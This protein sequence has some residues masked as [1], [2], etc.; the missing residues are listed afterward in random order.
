[1]NPDGRIEWLDT[2]ARTGR[3]LNAAPGRDAFDGPGAGRFA[4]APSFPTPPRFFDQRQERREL[5]DPGPFRGGG[6]RG[7]GGEGRGRRGR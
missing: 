1:M 7:Y 6:G 3:V 5:R 4:P 2:D